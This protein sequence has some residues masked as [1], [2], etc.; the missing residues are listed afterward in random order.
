MM[1][2]KKSC[3]VRTCNDNTRFQFLFYVYLSQTNEN[4]NEKK[5]TKI[6]ISLKSES[7]VFSARDESGRNTK[8]SRLLSDF[9]IYTRPVPFVN[10]AHSAGEDLFFS[11]IFNVFGTRS[12]YLISSSIDKMANTRALRF[13]SFLPKIFHG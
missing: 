4:L 8:I 1:M 7:I 13:D 5:T 2:M 10:L 11:S 6:P 3:S 12:Q 9:V